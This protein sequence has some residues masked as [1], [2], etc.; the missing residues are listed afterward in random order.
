MAEEILDVLAKIPRLTIIS[1]TS[2]FRFRG[3][4]VDAKVIGSTL[5]MARRRCPSSGA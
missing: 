5:T 1:R 4:D 3:R 2:S